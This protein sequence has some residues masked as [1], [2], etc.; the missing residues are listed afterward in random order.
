[1]D[2]IDKSKDNNIKI[3]EESEELWFTEFSK[4]KNMSQHDF[5]IHNTIINKIELPKAFLLVYDIKDII[6]FGLGVLEHKYIGV[7]D[8]LVD[9]LHRNKG[10]G[11]RIM[12]SLLHWGKSRGAEYSYLQV[13]MNNKAGLGLYKKFGYREVYKYWYRVKGSIHNCNNIVK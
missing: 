13:M 3:S 10:I 9:E 4:Q 8:I 11:F 6:G 5:E 7:Y 2:A 1:M 12:S